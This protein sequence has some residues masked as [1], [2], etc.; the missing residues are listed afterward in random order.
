MRTNK[1]DTDL[2][3]LEGVGDKTY[4]ALIDNG[5]S[6]M[7]SIAVATPADIALASGISTNKARKLIR[8]AREKV[9]LGLEKAKDFFDR[10]EKTFKISTGCPSFD[11]MLDGGFESGGI[12]EIYA[13]WGTG[14]TQ[15][16]H[17]MAVR[18]L[19]DDPK[20]KSIFVDSEN[21]FKA[22]RI[23]DFAEANKLKV[24]D[25]MDRI[26]IGRALSSDHQLLLVDEI[27][28]LI[29][30]DPTYRIIIVD[31]L[32]S[33]FRSEYSG[34][35]ELA[36]RQQ[37]LNKHMHQLLKI[38]DIYNLVVIVTNQVQSDPATF[39][40]N[41]EKPIGGNIVG[42]GSTSRIYMRPGKKGTIFA[43]LVD[44]PNLPQN[45]CNFIITKNGLEDA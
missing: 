19:V 3:K 10:R 37:R 21:T 25:V 14:K 45:E 32:T 16:S 2:M 8:S 5:F 7:M 28:N 36:S 4:K 9:T 23:K 30:K 27:E 24:D 40:G 26:M 18:A 11:K 13:R 42:H 34:R 12:I 31:S 6:T 20:A 22:E 33:H 44:S 29:Q 43:K 35:G 38:A 39:Y 41:P 1:M 17:L 15:L